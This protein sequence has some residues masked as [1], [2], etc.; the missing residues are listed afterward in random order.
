[1]MGTE[2]RGPCSLDRGAR[3]SLAGASGRLLG[4]AGVRRPRA[5]SRVVPAPGPW[6]RGA[7]QSPVLAPRGPRL[8]PARA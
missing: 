5:A 1:M 3:T 2:T 8:G 7:V 4:R 6:V